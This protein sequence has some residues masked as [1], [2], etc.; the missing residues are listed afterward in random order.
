[1]K[2]SF[3][4][5]VLGIFALTW[6]TGCERSKGEVQ[7]TTPVPNVQTLHPR[8]GEIARSITLPG[9]IRAYQQ[10]TLYAKVA[11]YLKTIRVDKGDR[12]KQ[13]DLVAEVEVPELLADRL[14]FKAEAE[15]AEIT[16][17]RLDEAQKKSPDLVVPKTVD[18]AR[19]NYN[20]ALANMKRVETLLDYAKIVAPFSGVITK[21]WVDPGAFIPAATSSSAAQNAAVVTLMDF[22]TV[23]ID[24]WMPESEVPLVKNGLPVNITVSE[25]PGRVFESRVTRIAYALDDATKNMAAEIEIP[26][27]DL[28]LR[29]GMYASVKI[30]LQ[31]KS[32]AILVPSEAIITEKNQSSVFT[33]VDGKVRKAA[34][35]TGFDDGISVELLDG[36]TPNDLVILAGKQS[37]SDGQQVHA[38]EVK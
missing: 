31:R 34:V 30:D 9:N 19:G 22:S 4:C 33:V 38:M 23:R 18:E 24:A 20:V 12:V 16:Y 21:R 17:K 15:V 2:T 27:P 36:V 1:M 26:N 7:A 6:M 13:G 28:E 8:R 14:K 37:I 11:G 10:A 32:D 35:K 3:I 29:P 5:A 25:L